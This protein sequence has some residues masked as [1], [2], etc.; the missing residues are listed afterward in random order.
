MNE[1]LIK[2]NTPHGIR[3]T[4]SIIQDTSETPPYC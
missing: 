3:H 4:N 1:T 2:K